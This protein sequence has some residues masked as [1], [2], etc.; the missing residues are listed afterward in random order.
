PSIMKRILVPLMLILMATVN[1]VVSPSEMQTMH[2]E[3]G[4]ELSIDV[5][6]PV[7]LLGETYLPPAGETPAADVLVADGPTFCDQWTDI[8]A[9]QM[10]AYRDKKFDPGSCFG[11]EGYEYLKN[12]ES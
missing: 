7:N 4:L 2:A 12:K 1:A 10:I 9:F 8:T 6:A 3:Q 5:T 11:M